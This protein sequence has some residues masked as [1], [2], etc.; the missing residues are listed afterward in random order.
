MIV[1]SKLPFQYTVAAYRQI[2]ILVLSTTTRI[3]LTTIIALSPIR[4][5]LSNIYIWICHHRLISNANQLPNQMH[6]APSLDERALRN[7]SQ[8]GFAHVSRTIATPPTPDPRV[9]VIQMCRPRTHLAR[10][11]HTHHD[12]RIITGAF[13]LLPLGLIM[14]RGGGALATPQ[15]PPPAAAP[16]CCASRLDCCRRLRPTMS[17][18]SASAVEN[19]MRSTESLRMTGCIPA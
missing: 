8:S 7:Q 13:V 4:L 12:R 19:W 16:V 5:L 11:S 14:S 6:R 18:L 10:P 2:E 15:A 17:R 1:V 9:F 3:S